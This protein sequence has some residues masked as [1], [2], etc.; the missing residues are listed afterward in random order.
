ME[1]LDKLPQEGYIIQM[2]YDPEVGSVILISIIP[3]SDFDR[4]CIARYKDG[5][6]LVKH[7]LPEED[8]YNFKMRLE[9]IIKKLRSQRG[10]S[11]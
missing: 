6:V 4:E 5:I 8:D 3:Y 9:E 7:R 10:L 11:N 2:P 1:I